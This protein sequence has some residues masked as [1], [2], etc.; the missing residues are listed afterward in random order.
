MCSRFTTLPHQARAVGTHWPATCHCTYHKAITSIFLCLRLETHYHRLLKDGLYLSGGRATHCGVL[1]LLQHNAQLKRHCPDYFSTV[2]HAMN[3]YHGD[4]ND[5][6]LRRKYEE[7][8]RRKRTG[9]ANVQSTHTPSTQEKPPSCNDNTVSTTNKTP[10]SS[11]QDS[12]NSAGG[13]SN[14]SNAQ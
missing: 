10:P 9:N 1:P 5:Q 4:D 3:T 2:A 6:E 14:T 13:S 7:V 8:Q 11:D 12:T